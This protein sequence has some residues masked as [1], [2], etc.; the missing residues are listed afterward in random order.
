MPCLIKRQMH[1]KIELEIGLLVKF[2]FSS[3]L[4]AGRITVCI[5]AVCCR[6]GNGK[7]YERYTVRPS[8]T[9][10][11]LKGLKNMTYMWNKLD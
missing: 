9:A 6:H 3:A 5:V 11:Y 2:L 7:K 10:H 1:F 8:N 4:V